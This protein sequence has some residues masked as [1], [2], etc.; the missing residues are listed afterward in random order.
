MRSGGTIQVS[1][2]SRNNKPKCMADILSHYQLLTR[3]ISIVSKPIKLQLRSRLCFLCLHL[4]FTL[5]GPCFDL[6]FVNLIFSSKFIFFGAIFCSDFFFGK[7]FFWR[8]FLFWQ[9]INLAK[10]FFGEFFFWQNF[11]GAKSFFGQT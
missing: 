2:P 1:H 7:F 5:P 6:F 9:K 8:I 11:F 3:L 4:T 10:I